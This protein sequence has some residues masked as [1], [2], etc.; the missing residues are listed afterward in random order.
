M[1]VSKE[2]G[3]TKKEGVSKKETATKLETDLHALVGAG[4]GSKNPIAGGPPTLAQHLSRNYNS[5]E[6]GSIR[7]FGE[8]FMLNR[9]ATGFVRTAGKPGSYFSQTAALERPLGKEIRVNNEKAE[10]RDCQLSMCVSVAWDLLVGLLAFLDDDPSGRQEEGLSKDEMASKP[11]QQYDFHGPQHR[12]FNIAKGKEEE[13]DV[14]VEEGAVPTGSKTPLASSSICDAAHHSPFTMKVT[15]EASLAKWSRSADE[16]SVK[17]R[18]D[19]DIKSSCPKIL[20][21]GRVRNSASLKNANT[22]GPA[23]LSAEPSV[24]AFS[25]R[26]VVEGIRDTTRCSNSTAK[27]TS[28]GSKTAK[29]TSVEQRVSFLYKSRFAQLNFTEILGDSTEEKMRGAPPSILEYILKQLRWRAPHHARYKERD[30]V[31]CEKKWRRKDLA[32]ISNGAANADLNFFERAALH[33]SEILHLYRE[34]EES[35]PGEALPSQKSFASEAT[36]SDKGQ[37]SISTGLESTNF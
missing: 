26:D 19:D 12:V 30:V 25:R 15:T 32:K 8:W 22:T 9:F 35:G 3:I 37:S 2:E 29:K 20:D 4:S 14:D 33:F 16:D 7:A 13:L 23:A 1:G 6:L 11:G 21:T 36:S 5:D 10:K 27:R 18:E 24:V 31:S 17:N 34:E 28:R